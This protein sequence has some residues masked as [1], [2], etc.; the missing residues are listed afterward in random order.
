MRRT[1]AKFGLPF[2]KA[3]QSVHFPK[4]L[5]RPRN[6]VG[7][8]RLWPILPAEFLAES[9]RLSRILADDSE[10]S[11]ILRNSNFRAEFLFK[12]RIFSRFSYNVEPSTGILVV[13]QPCVQQCATDSF[14]VFEAYRYYRLANR[15]WP[16]P[17]ILYVAQPWKPPSHTWCAEISP[18]LRKRTLYT[19]GKTPRNACS[20]VLYRRGVHS[21]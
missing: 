2:E 9:V 8:A 17:G 13:R 18:H 10:T 21:G 7:P 1:L 6:N 12:S 16:W 15:T 3:T 20:C 4:A 14:S 11:R 5:K 19:V